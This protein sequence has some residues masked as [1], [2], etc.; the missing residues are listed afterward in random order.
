[1]CL[2]SSS[3]LFSSDVVSVA[4]KWDWPKGLSGM[5]SKYNLFI[6]GIMMKT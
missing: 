6:S 4:A 1:M 2:H 5:G 3:A